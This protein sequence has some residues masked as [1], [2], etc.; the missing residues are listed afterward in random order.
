VTPFGCPGTQSIY[1]PSTCEI[2]GAVLQSLILGVF[3]VEP[4]IPPQIMPRA[5]CDGMEK[6][7]VS[8]DRIGGFRQFLGWICRPGIC[9]IPLKPC[10][11]PIPCCVQRAEELKYRR[12]ISGLRSIGSNLICRAEYKLHEFQYPVTPLI[13]GRVSGPEKFHHREPKYKSWRLLVSKVILKSP[14]RSLKG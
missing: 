5:A 8:I 12:R 1:L 6:A 7:E 9:T 2:A 13:D 4:R 14:E 10:W 11:D 3:F